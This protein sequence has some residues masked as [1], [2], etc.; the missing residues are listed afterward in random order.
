MNSISNPISKSI[1]YIPTAYKIWKHLAKG[2]KI[3]NGARKCKLCKDVFAVKHNLASLGEC[4]T[5]I[6]GI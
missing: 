5:Q 3:S 2:F 4:Y 6:G 1:I